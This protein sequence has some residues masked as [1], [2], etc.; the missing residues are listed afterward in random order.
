MQWESREDSQASAASLHFKVGCPYLSL[1]IHCVADS[2]IIRSWMRALQPHASASTHIC[3]HP[4]LC[5]RTSCM[6]AVSSLTLSS[7]LNA[8]ARATRFRPH[9]SSFSSPSH[10]TLKLRVNLVISK[11]KI[12]TNSNPFVLYHPLCRPSHHALCLHWGNT[13]L[14][15]PPM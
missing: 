4:D 13:A 10:L 14:N 12:E 2:E 9:F 5:E 1:D 15:Y 3:S 11:F 7:T 8:D 6:C